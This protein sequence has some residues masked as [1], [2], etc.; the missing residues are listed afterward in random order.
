MVS[1]RCKMAVKE[2]LRNM[3]I[4]FVFVELGVVETME[5]LTEE[6]RQHLKTELHQL[7]LELM[8]DKKSEL[9]QKVK[10]LI[11]DMIYH[12]E[13]E[14]K[15]SFTV[16]LSKHTGYDYPYL[17]NLFLEVQGT[18]IQQFIIQHKVERIKELIMYGELSITEITWKMNYSSVA[19]LS[20]QFKKVTGLTPSHFRE[21]KEKRLETMEENEILSN[22][23]K[24]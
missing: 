20:N 8:D 24:I 7:G 21:L 11:L 18:S 14:R 4:H 12:P 10:N 23:G 15:M 6:E 2:T 19:H 5:D 17:A 3:G 9:V 13:E 1:L 16:Y 22:Q